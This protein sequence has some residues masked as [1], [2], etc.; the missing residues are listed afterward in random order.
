MTLTVILEKLQNPA[1]SPGELSQT[2]IFL[3]AEYSKKSDE[4][5]QVLGMKASEW[6]KLRE[7]HESD[8]QADK[9]WD[10]MIEGRSEMILRLELK[11]LAQLMSSIKAHLRV[12][13]AEARNQF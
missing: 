10:A 13:D 1:T 9:A 12:K 11:N 6:P 4:F 8:K 2:L 5:A 3:S 7:K